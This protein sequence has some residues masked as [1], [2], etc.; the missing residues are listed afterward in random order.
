MPKK[1]LEDNFFFKKKGL[2]G[3]QYSGVPIYFQFIYTQERT[4]SDPIKRRDVQL[5]R[6]ATQDYEDVI[7]Y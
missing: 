6:E 4:K 7:P 2:V 3:R 1:R 5:N